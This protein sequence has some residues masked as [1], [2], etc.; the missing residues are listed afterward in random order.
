M[1]FRWLRWFMITARCLTLR[2]VHNIVVR[3]YNT[4]TAKQMMSPRGEPGRKTEIQS[5][6]EIMDEMRTS[7]SSML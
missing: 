1:Y 3:V 6:C 7:R 5:T 2:K 4:E